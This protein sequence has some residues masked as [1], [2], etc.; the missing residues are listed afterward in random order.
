MTIKKFL[1]FAVAS[2]AT[3]MPAMPQEGAAEDRRSPFEASLGLPNGVR[4]SGSVRP[5][6]E[7]VANTFVGGRSGSDELLSVRS[8]LLVELDAG[9]LT[10]VGELL[11]ARWL[12]GDEGNEAAGEIDTLEPAQMYVSAIWKDV[13]LPGAQL[14][15]DLG[16]FTMDVGS[17]RLVARAAFRNLL[18]GFDGA[19][20]VWTTADRLQVTAFAAL[21]TRREP[22]DIPSLQD[23]EVALNTTTD[24]IRFL[25]AHVEAPLPFGVR[26][27]V[28]LFGLDERDG[29]DTPSRNRDL[30]TAGGRL[31]RAASAGNWDFEVELA[32]QTGTAR[33]SASAM[34]VTDLDHEAMMLHLEAGF[35][36][37]APLSPRVS[38]LYDF[39]SGDESPL[40]GRSGR[41]DPLFGDRAFEFGPTSIWGAVARSNVSS[42]G[43]RLEFSPDA[44]SDVLLVVRHVELAQRR[45]RFA[46]SGVVD[47]AGA[48]GREVGQQV[49]V[50]HRRWLVEDSVRM[51]VGGAMLFDGAFLE[52]APNA[53][54]E[55][56]A[57][58]GY[59]EISWMF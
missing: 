42:P 10:V 53:T 46:N 2:L 27:E 19:R 25:G 57:V 5:R 28:Y 59:S 21:P 50:R 44:E 56:D 24:T 31:R 29:A 11:D 49:E 14:K 8:Q 26:G 4:I 9:P 38:F 47:A 35:S 6:Y 45:D 3:A 16:R 37:E 23:N 1:F 30:L 22:S 34:D 55:G 20:L 48:S 51:A 33:A 58:Y 54:G 12:D 52:R 40:D 41:F 7:T 32:R 36:F 39:A 43:V 17:R 13:L 18:Q 15:T